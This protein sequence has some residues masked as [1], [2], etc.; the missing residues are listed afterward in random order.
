MD[1]FYAPMDISE[2]DSICTGT[3]QNTAFRVIEPVESG[4]RPGICIGLSVIIGYK[5]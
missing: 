5:V 1:F 2:R 3:P 4:R